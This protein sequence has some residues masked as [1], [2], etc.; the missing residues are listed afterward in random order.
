MNYIEIEIGGKKRGF[1]FGLGFL[2]NI[3][4]HFNMDIAEFGQLMSRNPFKAIP[5]ILY[6]AHEYEVK[7]MG[8]VP[9]FT[10]IDF[11]MWVEDMPNGYAD[12]KVE[13]ALNVLLESMRKN[14]P[15]LKQA[16]AEQAK[17]K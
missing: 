17:K 4:D 7:R 16:E 11:E 15:G 9:D 8:D 14:V 5:S 12:E 6:F 13:A 10:I 3:L 2:G 1:R